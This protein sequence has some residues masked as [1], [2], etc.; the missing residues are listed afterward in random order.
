[1][2]DELFLLIAISIGFL[3][4]LSDMLTSAPNLISFFTIDK[5]SIVI[6]I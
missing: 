5:F 2:I 6:Y 3:P 1:M 4:L